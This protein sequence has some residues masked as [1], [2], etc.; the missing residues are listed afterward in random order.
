MLSLRIFKSVSRS[1][2][3]GVPAGSR[4][5]AYSLAG[6]PKRVL[7]GAILL[8]GLAVGAVGW[9]VMQ[10]RNDAVQGAV[11]ESG[12]IASILSGQLARSLDSIDTIILQI[13][14]SV[15]NLDLTKSQSLSSVIN[16]ESFRELINRYLTRLPWIFNIA[17]ADQDGHVLVTTAGWP[18][19]AINVA[20]RDYFLDARLH[21]DDKLNVSVPI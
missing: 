7:L 14:K 16:T 6:T 10:L 11:A 2:A 5:P 18:T 13:K 15:E 12:N 21:E 19:P 4:E 17:I 9:T 8:L 20:D 1:E 3:A